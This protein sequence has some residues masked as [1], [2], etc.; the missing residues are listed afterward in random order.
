MVRALVRNQERGASGSGLHTHFAGAGLG[1]AARGAEEVDEGEGRWP[2]LLAHEMLHGDGAD[3]EIGHLAGAEAGD[4]G[5]MLRFEFAIA[6]QRG[7]AR[8]LA[9]AGDARA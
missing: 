3:G 5:G 7:D 8:P 1:R 2:V 6:L 9:A 4:S